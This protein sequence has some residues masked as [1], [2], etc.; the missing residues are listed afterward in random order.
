MRASLLA[1]IVACAFA[2]C[3]GGDDDKVATVP[4]VTSPTQRATAAPEH[5]AAGRRA[6]A[7]AGCLA[8]HQIGP[9]GNSG[10]GSNLAGI[11]DRMPRSAIR[12]SLLDARAPMP[13]YRQL[14]R[15]RLEAIV[16]YLSSLRAEPSCPDDHDCG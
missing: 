12:R 14:P 5:V 3:G 11:G 2:G 16:A 7:D 4:T 9:R 15:D 8:C 6:V 10:P 13:S 1:C